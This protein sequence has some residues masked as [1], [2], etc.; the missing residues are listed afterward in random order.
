[1]LKRFFKSIKKIRKTSFP[2]LLGIAV[3]LIPALILVARMPRDV[4]AVWYDYSYGYRQVLPVTNN[5]TSKSDWPLQVIIDTATLIGASKMQA[6]CDDARFVLSDGT[7]LTYFLEDGCN[8]SKT[9]FWVEIPSID[10]GATEINFYYSNAVATSSSTYMDPSG[11]INYGNGDDGDIAI[12][13]DTNINTANSIS[14]R[15]CADGGDAVNYTVT[16]NRSAGTNQIVLSTTPSSGCLAIG[17]EVLII[18]LMGTSGA[19]TDVGEWES[20]RITAINTA[21]LTLNHNLTEG[22]NGTTQQIMVQRIPN[23]NDVTLSNSGTDFIASDFNGT[24]G[25]VMMFRADGT[26]T[27]AANTTINTNA[28]GYRGGSAGTGGA[29]GGTNGESYDGIV[30]SGGSSAN[31]GTSGGGDG[32]GHATDAPAGAIRGGGGGGGSSGNGDS[33]NNGAGGGGGAYGFGGGGGGGGRDGTGTSGTGGTAAS[34]SVNGGGG[35]GGRQTAGNGGNGG[36]AGSAGT[37]STGTGGAVGSGTTSGAGGGGSGSNNGSG[38]GGGGGG[39]YGTSTLASIYLGSG[40]G[41][42]GDSVVTGDAT[43]GADGGGILYIGANTVSVSGNIQAN[44]ATAST[45]STD[46]AGTGGSGAGGSI[47]IT[48]TSITL[49]SSL[50]TSTGG[51]VVSGGSSTAGGG[52]GGDGRI[53]VTYST[54][55]GSTLP[56]STSTALPVAGTINTEEAA[57]T[58]TGAKLYWKFDEGYGTTAHDSAEYGNSGVITNSLWREEAYCKNGKC[59]YFDGSGDLVSK[60][61]DIDLNFV[62]SD[63]FTI[64][65]W[66]KHPPI[67][68]NPDFLVAKHESGTAGG[69]K[70]YMDSDGDIAFGI[71]DDGTWGPEDVIGDDQNK[72][73][74]DN[75]WHHFAAVKDGTTGIYLYVDGTLI[76]SDTSLSATGSLSNAATFYLGIEAD[77]SSN[78]WSGFID[79][80]K[81]F[82]EVRSIGQIRADLLPHAPEQGASASFGTNDLSILSNGLVGYWKMDESLWNGTTG[83]VLD[84]SGNSN[85]GTATGTPPTTGTGKFGKAGIFNGTNDYISCGSGT[86]ITDLSAF[87]F[88]TWVKTSASSASALFSFSSSSTHMQ[89]ENPTNRSLLQLGSD[90]Y[91]YF[92]NS[93]VNLGDGNWH[94]VVFTMPGS[95]QFDILDAKMYVDGVLQTPDTTVS[96]NVQS[97]KT[98]CNISRYATN[99]LN[100]IQDEVRLYNRVLSQ[101]EVNKLYNYAPGPVAH[102]KLDEN[103]GTTTTYDSSTNNNNLALYNITEE[104]WSKG[105]LGSSLDLEVASSQDA[106]VADNALLSI[107][108]DLTLAA[109]IKPES[110]TAAT[111]FGIIGKGDIG[112]TSYALAQYGDEVRVYIGS[113]SNYET[114]DASNLTVDNWYHIEAVYQAADQTVSIYINGNLQPSTTTGTIPSSIADDT[115]PFSIGSVIASTTTTSNFQVSASANDAFIDNRDLSLSSLT[116]NPISAGNV[117]GNENSTLGARFTGINIPNSATIS[118]ATF[119][120]TG[121]ADWDSSPEQIRPQVALQDADNPSAF[122]TSA[123]NLNTSTRPRTSYTSNWNLDDVTANA[124]YSIAVTSLVQTVVNRGGWSSGNAMVVLVDE[125]GSSDPSQWQD[126]WS[127]DGDSAKAPELSVSY[128][129]IG[130][131]YYDGLIDDLKVYNYA[132]SQSQITED[133]NGGHPIGGSPISSRVIQYNFD[134]QNG[135]T[136]NNSNSSQSAITGSISG[137]TWLLADNC[138]YT[139]CLDFDGSNDVATVTNTSAIDFDSG[140][141]SSFTISAWINPDTDGEADTGQIFYKGTNTWCRTDSESGGYVDIE[142]SLDLATTDATLNVTTALPINTWSHFAVSYSD[143]ADDEIT[144]YINGISVG[145]STNGV[146]SPASGDNNDLLVGGT[147]TNNFDGSID[148]FKLYAAE[149]TATQILI[150]KNANAAAN[151]GTGTSEAASLEGGD[152]PSLRGWWSLDDNTGTSTAAERSGNNYTSTLN[153]TMTESDWVS[154]KFGSALAFDGTDDAIDIENNINFSNTNAFSISAWIYRSDVSGDQEIV[155]KKLSSGSGDSGYSIYQWS[156]GNGGNTCLYA[157][158]GTNQYETCTADDTTT[159]LNEWEHIVV[160]YDNSSTT[161]STIYINGANAEH[162]AYESGSPATVGSISNTNSLCIGSAGSGGADCSSVSRHF[163]GRIDDVR[164]YSQALTPQQVAYLYNRG[165]PVAWY[166]LDEC[167][168]TDIHDSS[169]N[170]LHGTLE[171]GASGQTATGDCATNANT[172]WYN[173]SDGKYNASLNFDGTDDYVDLGDV[174]D[175]TS[176]FSTVGWVKYADLASEAPIINKLGGVGARDWALGNEGG[177]TGMRITIS[178]D[179]TNVVTRYA[180]YTL[181]V[182]EWVHVAG[183]YDANA[184]TLNIYINGKLANGSL[185]GAVPTGI[186][187]TANDVRIG[188]R[189]SNASYLEGQ[190]DDVRMYNYPLSLAQIQQIM[191]QGAVRFGPQ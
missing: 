155:S 3:I 29:V 143:D 85:N 39:S 33:S 106:S 153:G 122:A 147:T 67:A 48:G 10:A 128:T 159:T 115:D 51:S 95:A 164:I 110:V 53:Y 118:S 21:T 86:S 43:A 40:G 119:T 137:A 59:L 103:T 154:G 69:Y 65:G 61:N 94:H 73:Y 7:E 177:A 26:V 19:N 175:M 17:D 117:N 27:V 133:M 79:E 181:V 146:G 166:K 161:G 98:A 139:G 171:V 104:S 58:L 188:S 135:S 15:S 120:L 168:G 75:R 190:L 136:A 70:I 160:V 35:G 30:G 101:T 125:T 5:G 8:T 97:S 25:G 84:Y 114:T 87:S 127:Y 42:G 24:K 126:F 80:I 102:Y 45:A 37:S 74:D 162:S 112:G 23:Y 76:D 13:S 187:A 100:G 57:P 183:V 96:S 108:S 83:E 66:F 174:L 90:N 50:V 163:S 158:D 144:I 62:A 14:G 77:G 72:D 91:R 55:S 20:A 191:N 109:W 130:S 63:D 92:S 81:V 18:N 99:Y 28:L 44:G 31:A 180:D 152:L 116:D 138:K 107:T 36:S 82:D 132:R 129:I 22:Y 173:G 93:N 32:G 9:I 11:S 182:G 64:M 185:S 184:Q 167:T 151:V 1:M 142:C 46:R 71:D 172:P 34:G 140:I 12:S 179:N 16:E 38:G 68:T 170:A 6:D 111:A 56:T 105:K 47:Y 89:I 186:A 149:L 4:S 88:A 157:A 121:H 150:D 176:S 78:S 54:T 52:A 60:A 145:N 141:A 156:S 178:P 2:L 169:E 41:G 189:E 49:G 148:D 123:A 124:E 134:E 165:E 113:L 131:A